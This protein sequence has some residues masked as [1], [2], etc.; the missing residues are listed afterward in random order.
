MVVGIRIPDLSSA[1]GFRRLLLSIKNTG[2]CFL[3]AQETHVGKDGSEGGVIIK[4]WS[5]VCIY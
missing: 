5:V 2:L 3:S 4:S 1:T